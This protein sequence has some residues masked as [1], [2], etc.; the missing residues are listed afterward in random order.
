MRAESALRLLQSLARAGDDP[1]RF[2]QACLDWSSLS[3]DATQLPDFV[4]ILSMMSPASPSGDSRVD[5][6]KPYTNDA[7]AIFEMDREGRITR[8]SKD[9][10]EQF[11]LSP[12]DPL[13]NVSRF[14]ATTSVD[15][16]AQLIE[17]KDRFGIDRHIKIVPQSRDGSLIGFLG[18]TTQAKLAAPVRTHLADTAALTQTEIDILELVTGR[19]T[20]EQIAD[21]RGIKLNTVRT[22]IARI[23]HKLGSHSLVETVSAVME[24]SD[25]LSLPILPPSIP[26]EQEDHA[27]RQI[28]LRT[29]GKTVE[30]R[31]YGAASGVPVIILHSLEYGYIPSAEM[32]A[33]ARAQGVNLIFP[34]R[35]GF[36]A[37]SS[38][39]SVGAAASILAEF[40]QVL[41]VQ[42]VTLIGLSTAA[43]LAL[44]LQ[45]ISPRIACTRLINYGLN[46]D[47]KISAIQPGWISG[48]LR[49]TLNSPSSFAIGFGA[50][51][52]MIR[53]FGGSRFYRMLYRNQ[54][55]DLSYLEQNEAH[56]E[57]MATYISAADRRMLRLDIE[58][59]FLSNQDVEDVLIRGQ[60]IKVINTIDQHG[61]GPET[62]AAEAARLN[63]SIEH[64]PHAGR[65]WIFQHPE[66][67]LADARTP[68]AS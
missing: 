5:V 46:A 58:T 17:L 32:T 25:T 51:G 59:A 49:M 7:V 18:Y 66:A 60:N 1:E 63:V 22:H 30:Y 35:P 19:H 24:L 42:N 8:L 23:N 64:V 33:L 4:S 37:T 44:K 13:P 55:A 57:A 40:L 9:L 28:G 27:T 43:P 29:K 31:R 20:L 2:K 53:T 6:G 11:A 56:F 45:D 62:S 10:S 48:M 12:G 52:S 41:A 26:S 39:D 50:L 16:P 38:A 68:V 15:A 3:D 67:V 14:D 47:D 61:I 21:R 54:S 34:L 36:G 65:N